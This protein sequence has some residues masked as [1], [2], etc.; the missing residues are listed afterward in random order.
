VTGEQVKPG[1]VNRGELMVFKERQGTPFGRCRTFGGV[2]VD[3]WLNSWLEKDDT[4]RQLFLLN[5]ILIPALKRVEVLGGQKSLGGG[6]VILSF[7]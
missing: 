1:S 3:L 2:A 7:G 6:K 5:E 4:K